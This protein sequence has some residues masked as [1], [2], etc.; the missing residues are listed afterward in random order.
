MLLNKRIVI[1]GASGFL[2]KFLVQKLAKL[3]ARLE[4]YSRDLDRSLHL[5][6]LGE[7]GQITLHK[8]RG[9]TPEALDQSIDGAFAI[10]NLIGIL[11]P[12]GKDTFTKCHELI[13]Q[14]LAEAATRQKVSHFIHISALGADL[15]SQSA[16]GRSKA[17]GEI[18]IHKAFAK[19]TILRPSVLI[20]PGELFLSRFAQMAQFSPFLPLIYQGKTRFQP[21]YAGDVAEAVAICLQND[22][23]DGKTF[24]LGGSEILTFKEILTRVLGD[25]KRKPYFLDLPNGIAKLMAFVGQYLPG[26]PFSPSELAMLKT[27]SVVHKN[28]LGFKELGIKPQPFSA[29]VGPCLERFERSF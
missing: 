13:P 20:G 9:F 28:S 25:I 24:E 29:W 23:T 26:T 14:A 6:P 11:A 12:K 8:L 18:L 15:K 3:G 5:K 7:P 16:Y 4:I 27:D 2:G 19:A 22:K 1:Y 21:V 17:Q 10:I